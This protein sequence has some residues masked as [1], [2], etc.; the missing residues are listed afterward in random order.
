MGVLASLLADPDRCRGR[1]AQGQ[2]PRHQFNLALVQSRS[3][4][5]FHHRF[6]VAHQPPLPRRGRSRR[7]VGGGRSAGLASGENRN[8]G[9]I[10]WS[11]L[12]GGPGDRGGRVGD[13]SLVRW[14]SVSVGGLGHDPVAG[15][16]GR[17]D[18]SGRGRGRRRDG[19]R[20]HQWGRMDGRLCW[21]NQQPHQ[22][23]L[24]LG[25]V[26]GRR[27]CRLCG[28]QCR[29]PELDRTQHR[30]VGLQLVPRGPG[31]HRCHDR[32]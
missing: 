11:H 17:F 1:I 23:Y 9:R 32:G 18:Q 24:R 6:G 8:L 14:R 31:V 2:R 15:K 25:P 20:Q 26:R 29:W 21:Q 19:A 10:A 13:G 7:T 22:Y 30:Q 4:R 28:Q 16:R 3:L 5:Q 27:R 12:F